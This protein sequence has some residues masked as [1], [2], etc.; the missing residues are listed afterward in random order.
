MMGGIPDHA[1]AVAVLLLLEVAVLLLLE[2]A[3]PSIHWVASPLLV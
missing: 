2:V 3:V 1:V